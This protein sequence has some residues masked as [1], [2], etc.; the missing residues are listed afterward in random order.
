MTTEEAEAL[1]DEDRARLGVQLAG[2]DES[3]AASY[4]AEAAMQD[5]ARAAAHGSGDLLVIGLCAECKGRKA[6]QIAEARQFSGGVVFIGHGPAH[7]GQ[8]LS[9]LRNRFRSRGWTQSAGPPM[10]QEKCLVILTESP[11]PALSATCPVHGTVD[12][13]DPT[14]VLQLAL[15]AEPGWPRKMKITPGGSTGA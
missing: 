14:A 8:Q 13:I 9:V 15:S 2:T 11:T 6:R 12:D 7:H 5:R 3:V 1:T 4:R 10:L